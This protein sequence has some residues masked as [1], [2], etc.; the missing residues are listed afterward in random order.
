LIEINDLFSGYGNIQVLKNINL[1]VRSGNL[2]TV[3]GPNGAGKSTLLRTISGL[4]E[5]SKGTI[6]VDGVNI[7]NLRPDEIVQLGIIHVPEGRMILSRLTVR[8]NLIMG[9]FKRK[10]DGQI[11][12]DFEKVLEMFPILS[13]RINQFGGTLSGGEQQM[14]AIGRGIMARPKL[15]MLDEPSLGIAP[16]VVEQIF[17]MIKEIQKEGV[18]ILMVEQNAAKALNSAD[19]GYVLELGKIKANG[20]AKDL[21]NDELIKKSYLG[22]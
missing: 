18:T 20:A 1:N 6:I 11:K 13:E 12:N 5:I 7:C 19:T 15:L 21:L 17:D 10:D 8:E 3:I 9:S 22:I 16:I 4:T 14:L 2:T